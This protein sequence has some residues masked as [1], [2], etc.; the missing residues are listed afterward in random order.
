MKIVLFDPYSQK[1]TQDMKE[2][3][4]AHGHEVL[5]DRYYNPRLIHEGCDVVWFDT[6][7][8]NIASATNPG[9]AIIADD[10]NYR[11][12]DIHDMD[13]SK[14]QVVCRPIDI[15]V[16]QG[17][18]GNVKCDVV[19]D[20]IF[21]APHIRKEFN[22][23]DTGAMRFHNI[24]CGV[25]L[26]RYS[27]KERKPGFDIAV[28]SERWISKGTDLILQVAL[29][30]QKIDPRYK[31]HWLGQRSDYQWEHAYFDEFIE[32][33]N[34]NIEITNVLLDGE[35][36]DHWLEDKNYLLH[37][38]HKEAFSYATAEAMAKG[39]KPVLHRFYGA[40]ALWP[41]MTW[42]SV[43][44][45]IGMITSENYNSNMYLNF[46]KEQGYTLDQMMEKIMEVISG[47]KAKYS[48][49]GTCDGLC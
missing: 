49:L 47:R 12:W 43:D 16:W 33:H 27:F 17:H 40:D 2:W 6:C 37:A 44:E 22:P 36:V 45:A 25:N 10:A 1:F 48:S 30:L 13:L 3:W 5:Y 32:H 29:K 28:I 38:S 18:Q 24:P 42:S 11:P 34:L 41:D 39:I 46:L 4:E 26:D 14:T 8:N 19:D 20:C 21:I 35:T 7:D 23:G 15:E 31:I 9:V